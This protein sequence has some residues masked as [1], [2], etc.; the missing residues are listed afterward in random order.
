MNQSSSTLIDNVFKIA[1]KIKTTTNLYR[2]EEIRKIFYELNSLKYQY[3]GLNMVNLYME[4]YTFP[5]PY[6]DRSNISCFALNKSRSMLA[7][8]E[9]DGKI[10]VFKI[11]THTLIKTLKVSDLLY[12][13]SF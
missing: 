1:E 9:T 4:A 12:F 6:H 3:Q 2:R 10:K 8:G 5:K 13:I 7:I 11:A